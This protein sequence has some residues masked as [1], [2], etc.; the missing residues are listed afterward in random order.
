VL[1]NHTKIKKTQNES[2]QK[3]TKLVDNVQVCK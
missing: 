3:L 2:M 1:D